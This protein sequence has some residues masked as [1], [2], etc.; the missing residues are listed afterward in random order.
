[1]LA[2]LPFGSELNMHIARLY[3]VSLSRSSGEQHF[4]MTASAVSSGSL[5]GPPFSEYPTPGFNI[6]R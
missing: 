2:K 4:T 6:P 5:I 3:L 1:M